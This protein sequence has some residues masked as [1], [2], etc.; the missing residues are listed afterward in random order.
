[1]KCKETYFYRKAPRSKM[2]EWSEIG[3]AISSGKHRRVVDALR[4]EVFD[5]VANGNEKRVGKELDLPRI[6]WSVGEEGY[7]GIVVL[8]LP[9]GDNRELLDSLRSAVNGLQQVAC[10]FVGSSG[11]TLKVLMPYTLTDG[12]LPT[13]D[14][15]VAVFHAKAHLMASAFVMQITGVKALEKDSDWQR[16]SAVS[17]D[18][19]LYMN[20][21]ATPVPLAMPEGMPKKLA[22]LESDDI[23]KQDLLPDYNSVEMAVTKFNMLCRRMRLRGD[24]PLAEDALSLAREC[25]KMGIPE[26]IAVKCTLS[27]GNQH[28]K[29]LLIRTSFENVYAE[30]SMGNGKVL[31]KALMQQQLL[32]HFLKKR[33]RFRRNVITDSMEYAEISKYGASWM[34]LTQTVQN[35]ICLAAQMAGIEV[36]DKDLQRYLQSELV[37]DYDPIAEWL[38]TLPHWDGVDRVAQLAATVKTDNPMWE[39]DFRLWMRSMVSQWMNRGGLYGASMALMLVGKQ[40]TRKSTFCKRLMPESMLTY[41]TDRIDFVNKR[42]AERA[43]IRFALICIDEF[44]QISKSQTAYLKHVLQKSDIKYRKMYQDDIEQRRRYAAFCA[45]TN[46]PTP[47]IDP[48]GSRRYL[49]VEVLDEIDTSQDIDYQQLYAQI[50]R[51]IRNGEQTYFSADDER[52]IQENNSRFYQEQPI[53]VFVASMFAKPENGEAGEWMTALDV[54]KSLHNAVSAVRCDAATVRN[55][56]KVLSFNAFVRK[57][58]SSGHLYWVKRLEKQ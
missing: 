49:C 45:T 9:F 56:G 20:E 15:D 23:Y 6:H 7:N 47:L 13:N 34:P 22:K 4:E 53:E 25:R 36:W 39:H 14:D 43:L 5:A 41:Y 33:Y 8:T 50:V 11:R 24:E 17:V 28:E 55:V 40:G 30:G 35:T 44:D 10:S 51:E 21:A 46:S 3:V 52:R 12:T 19:L 2:T 29:E 37:A 27:L 18:E 38:Y 32:L 42:E 26:E 16:G 54:A 57:R 31:P 58:S 48:T 1:M